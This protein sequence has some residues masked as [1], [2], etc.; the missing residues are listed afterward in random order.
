LFR[1]FV[2]RSNDVDYF[3]NDGAHEL[4]TLR[5]GGPGWWLRG[6]GDTTNPRDVAGVFTTSER[7]AV[8]GYDI[9]VAAPRPISILVALDP[10]QA[11]GVIEAHRVSVRA[12]LAYLEDRA[13]LV[14][15]RAQGEDH[16][17]AAKWQRIVSFTHGLNRHGEPHLHDHVLVGARPRGEASV[18]DSRALFAHVTT[19]DALYRASLRHELHQRTSWVAWRSFKGIEHVEGVDEGYRSLWGGHH[20]GRGEKLTWQR[21]ETLEKWRDDLSRFQPEGLVNAPRR[22]RG[23]LDEHAFSSALEGHVDVTR[24]QVVT[25]WANAASFG[26]APGELTA[27]IDRL[28][29]ELRDSR[30]VRERTIGVSQ[31]RMTGA[32]RE[33]GPRPLRAAEI[34]TWTQ[35]ER[36]RSG[37]WSE[38]SR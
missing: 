29:P 15:D 25:A 23:E 26:Q 3:T 2:R 37:V 28:Y 11:P 34:F 18:V 16:D 20:E 38:R 8:K 4:D 12:S 10:A 22:A 17:V 32:V 33:R 13:L 30:G 6:S 9:V 24:R 31:A 14:R 36:E 19:A 1:L 27:S 5:D 21:D 35:R 7:S